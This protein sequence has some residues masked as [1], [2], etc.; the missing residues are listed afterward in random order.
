S[1]AAATFP[2]TLPAAIVAYTTLFRSVNVDAVPLAVDD[3]LG[4]KENAALAI[5]PATLLSNDNQGTAPATV[6]SVSAASTQGGTVTLGPSADT[7][8]PPLDFSCTDT[9]TYTLTDA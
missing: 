7:H 1:S 2:Y 8:T 3:T 6:T 5:A 9:C 4:A